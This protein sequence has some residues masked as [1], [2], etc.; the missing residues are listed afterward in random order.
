MNSEKKQQIVFISFHGTGCLTSLVIESDQ[1]W[2]LVVEL[3]QEILFEDIRADCL[4]SCPCELCVVYVDC[5][6][7]LHVIDYFA[8][9]ANVSV[10]FSSFQ[11][12]DPRV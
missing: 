10:N 11:L 1:S 7:V 6:L 4:P 8:S 3:F 12:V 9:Y 5:F 2:L